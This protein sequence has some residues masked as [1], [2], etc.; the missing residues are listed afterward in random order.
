M[1]QSQNAINL[2]LKLT[3]YIKSFYVIDHKLRLVAKEQVEE[4]Q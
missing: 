2:G 3:A 4:R 1:I